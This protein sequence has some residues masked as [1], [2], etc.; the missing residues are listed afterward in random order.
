MTAGPDTGTVLITGAARGIGAATA[1]RMATSGWSV[2][3]FDRDETVGET[4]AS[5]ESAGGRALAC[6]G[7]VTSESDWATAIERT[8]ATF[9]PIDSLV[10]NA[11]ATDHTPLHEMA[12]ASWQRQL[13]VN[14]TGT[15]HGVRACLP[16]LRRD[17]HGAIVIVSSVHAG[18]G[19]PGVPAYAAT[20]AGLTGLTRQLATEYGGEVRVNC[21][22]PG[23]ILTS[24]WDGIDEE[25][26]AASAAETVIGRLGDPDEVAG[27]I[28]FLL[29]ASASFVTGATLTVDGGWSITK[30]SS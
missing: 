9:G 3:L 8:H 13:D 19:L 28:E 7:D 29:G 10:C 26:R 17:R 15:F 21:V 16:D 22:L 1:R 20:K 5:I 6:H 25:D 18:F 14:L 2:V 4:A 23:P 12:L 11:L 30:N 27:P 24:Q